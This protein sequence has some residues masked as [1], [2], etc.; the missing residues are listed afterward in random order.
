MF[1]LTNVVHLFPDEFPRLCAGRLSFALVFMSSFQRLFF[2]H[3]YLLLPSVVL[4]LSQK[5]RS[6]SVGFTPVC[7]SETKQIVEAL[8]VTGSQ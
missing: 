7:C 1:S 8:Y 5:H 3:V 2:R 4:R 6:F